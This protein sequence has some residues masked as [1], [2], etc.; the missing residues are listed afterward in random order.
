MK[1]VYVPTLCCVALCLSS[2]LAASPSR[3]FIQEE[4][5]VARNGAIF[6]DL[7]NSTG[8]WVTPAES[9]ARISTPKGE[10]ILSERSLSFKAR[11]QHNLAGYIHTNFG[12]SPLQTNMRLGTAYR[13]VNSTM[14]FN[15][16]PEFERFQGKHLININVAL[17]LSLKTPRWLNNVQ[18]GGEFLATKKANQRTG[19]AFGFRWMP[20][21]TLT[22]D[23]I[24]VGDGG[25]VNDSIV[26]T[27]AALR[28]NL[29]I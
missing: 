29:R 3:L 8:R 12:A 18:V 5:R 13:Y 2:L 22:V 1:P 15:L 25:T 7:Y 21:N 27:P 23:V 26:R 20:R 28:I 16:N 17:F 14:L 6:L 9:Q 11:W 10:L 4:G 24:I 19:I